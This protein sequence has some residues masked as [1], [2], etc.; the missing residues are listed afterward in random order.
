MK[1]KFNELATNSTNKNIRDLYR[2]INVFK[3]GSRLRNILVKDETG[4][5]LADS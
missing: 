3:R 4:D 2:G 1:D 5:L